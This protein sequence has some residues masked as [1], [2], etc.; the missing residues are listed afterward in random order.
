MQE[1]PVNLAFSTVKTDLL[2]YPS[3]NFDFQSDFLSLFLCKVKLLL[4]I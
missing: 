4:P 2:A 1:L 3:R